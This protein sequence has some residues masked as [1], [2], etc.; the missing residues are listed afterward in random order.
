MTANRGRL[1]KVETLASQE[2]CCDCLAKQGRSDEENLM[3][4]LEI[5]ARVHIE[6]EDA[7]TRKDLLRSSD[8][9]SARARALRAMAA[10]R[11]W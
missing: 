9:H 3:V 11:D 7:M 5:A 4:V 8:S 1:S 6:R 10:N 2:L